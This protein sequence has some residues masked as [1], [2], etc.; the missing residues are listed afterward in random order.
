MAKYFQK[1]LLGLLLPATAWLLPACGTGM[2]VGIR[3]T[4]IKSITKSFSGT[5]TSHIRYM[6]KGMVYSPYLKHLK[7]LI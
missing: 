2:G 5:L 7:L 6:Q 1:I 3:K 4:E